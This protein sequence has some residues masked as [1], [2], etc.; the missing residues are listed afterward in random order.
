MKLAALLLFVGAT[1]AT[2][3]YEQS[4]N[5]CP[6]ES[7][8]GQA[9]QACCDQLGVTNHQRGCWVEGNLWEQFRTCCIN[10]WGCDGVEN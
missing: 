5:L 9:T 7:G 1:S 4:S 8:H 2:W 3:C 10:Q 6:K